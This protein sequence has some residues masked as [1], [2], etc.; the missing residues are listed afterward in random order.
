MFANNLG[1]VNSQLMDGIESIK[2]IIKMPNLKK[3][4]IQFENQLS[5]IKNY[6]K[7]G[8]IITER[9]DKSLE[10]LFISREKTNL[11]N[12]DNIIEEEIEIE[13]KQIKQSKIL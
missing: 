13:I 11:L 2:N 6:K 12:C 1:D 3:I 10:F 7:I 5:F 4:T 8:E 9:V